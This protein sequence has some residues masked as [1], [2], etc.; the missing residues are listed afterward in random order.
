MCSDASVL[1][2]FDH[3]MLKRGQGWE[4]NSRT[5]GCGS[6]LQDIVSRKWA[7]AI[8]ADAAQGSKAMMTKNGPLNFS[9]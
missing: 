8:A 6:P 9:A 2:R 5:V 1:K 4:E 7:L 3:E